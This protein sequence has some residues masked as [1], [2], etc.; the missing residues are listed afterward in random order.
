ME[1]GR[2][3]V[4]ALEAVDGTPALER[5]A[6]DSRPWQTSRALSGAGETLRAHSY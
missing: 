2:V 4:A 5:Q 1:G 3:H 6:S